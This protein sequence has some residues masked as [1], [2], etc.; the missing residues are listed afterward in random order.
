[1]ESLGKRLKRLREARHL[2]QIQVAQRLGIS[3]Q[4]VRKWELDQT[5]DL[6]RDNLLGVCQIYGITLEALLL[7]TS[8]TLVD[9]PPAAPGNADPGPRPGRLR[10]IPIVGT[11]Q[12][13]DDG[14]WADLEYPTG[15]GDG[16]ILLA[17]PDQ[18]AY[19]IRCR[20]DSMRPRIQDGEFVIVCPSRAAR[21]GDDVLIRHQDGR[22]MV[23]RLLY[24]RDGHIYLQS[25]NENYPSHKFAMADIDV[26][27]PVAAICNTLSWSPDPEP[28]DGGETIPATA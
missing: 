14:Y 23:K 18:N 13:G 7:G 16:A 11:A 2:S 26:M 1:M 12:L 4:A 19:A 6:R 3:R 20:G 10:P 8:V 9:D 24:L 17:V 27:H 5:K 21:S 28:V 25:I 15:G 22:V